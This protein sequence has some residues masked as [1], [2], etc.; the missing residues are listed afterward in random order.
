MGVNTTLII[1]IVSILALIV[2]I[3]AI[4]VVASALGNRHHRSK[5]SG[6]SRK[7]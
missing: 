2:T 3:F 6:H 1:V 7:H 5:G 4:M